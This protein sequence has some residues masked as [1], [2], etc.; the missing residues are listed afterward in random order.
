MLNSNHKYI[1]NI[2]F[3][4]VERLAFPSAQYNVSILISPPNLALFF[5]YKKLLQLSVCSDLDSKLNCIAKTTTFPYPK[6]VFE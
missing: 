2:P 4:K 6:Q 1:F 3:Q 5:L